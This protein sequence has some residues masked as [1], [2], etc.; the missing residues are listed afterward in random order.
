MSAPFDPYYK[1]L[2]IAAD[3]Q[4]ATLY[5]LLGLRPFESDPD[6]IATAAEQRIQL[7]KTFQGGKYSQLSGRLVNEISRARQR[8]LD[9]KE[10]ADYDALLHEQIR[11]QTTTGGGSITGDSHR[12]PLWPE[13]K[14]PATIEEFYQIV[15]AS[16]IMT[17]SEVQELHDDFPPDRRPN[18]LKGL[19][20][21]LVRA[22]KL[23]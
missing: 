22:G 21:E 11:R 15:A 17:F 6:V 12:L 10:R 2:G 23:T 16:G 9:P 7:L 20:T 4:P 19:A 8:L 14:V 3:E 1:W 5:R 18:D 13:S